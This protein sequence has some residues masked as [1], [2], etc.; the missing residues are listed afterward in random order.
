MKRTLILALCLMSLD[1]AE[2]AAITKQAGLTNEEEHRKTE[3]Q[4]R[5][6]A[7]RE[8]SCAYVTALLTDPRLTIY[9]P[10]EPTGP[11]RAPAPKERERNPYLTK[12]FGLLTSESL[13]RC[14]E[15]VQA[16]LVAFNAAY[17]IYGVPREVICG[18]LRIETDFGIPTKLSPNPLGTVPAIDRLVTLYVRRPTHQQPR[19][20]FARRQAFAFVELKDLLHAASN[21]HWDLFR[22][23]GSSTGAI[24]LVQFEPSSFK[25]AVDGDGDGNINL[26]DP[27]DAILSLAHYL[28]TRGWDDQPQHQQR[29]IYAYYGGHYDSDPN[30]YYMKAV[31]KYAYEMGNYLKDHPVESGLASFPEPRTLEGREPSRLPRAGQSL[32]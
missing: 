6:C 10:P 29:A 13:E 22:V 18:H 2:A 21:F 1:A 4:N 7:D 11:R 17:Q 9:N 31:L 5:L 25:V 32:N 12:R 3:L 27:E 23:P 28:V 30:K 16:H 15:F 20:R 8:L 19:D 24:G 26:F 14:R